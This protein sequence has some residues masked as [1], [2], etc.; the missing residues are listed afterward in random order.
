[1]YAY[2]CVLEC[3]VREALYVPSSRQIRHHH[4]HAEQDK[5]HSWTTDNSSS[6]HYPL[7][8]F[9]RISHTPMRRQDFLRNHVI[10]TLAVQPSL[11]WH[12]AQKAQKQGWPAHE[13]TSEDEG[14][15]HIGHVYFPVCSCFTGTFPADRDQSS[16]IL[17]P[18][19]SQRTTRPAC[20]ARSRPRHPHPPRGPA[21]LT[22]PRCPGLCHTS[23]RQG[24]SYTAHSRSLHSIGF[25]SGQKS[26]PC[27][28]ELGTLGRDGP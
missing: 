1:M 5:E 8:R 10:S 18:V 7:S 22:C 17:S 25:I 6:K 19:F 9:L 4:G 11:T 16:G 2:T 20:P 23:Q 3:A 15:H 27:P 21:T 28:L 12:S 24:A 14:S 13:I 26:H